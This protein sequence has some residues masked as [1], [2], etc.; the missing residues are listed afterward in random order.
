MNKEK[1]AK[2]LQDLQCC[3]D[4][5]NSQYFTQI[6]SNTKL[7]KFLEKIENSF[8]KSNFFF[9]QNLLINI[10]IECKINIIRPYENVNSHLGM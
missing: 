5:M 9:D 7:Q 1:E 3:Y 4:T 6:W 2:C 8:L 10:E